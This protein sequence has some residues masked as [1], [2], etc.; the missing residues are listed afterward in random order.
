MSSILLYVAL[1]I[2]GY[3]IY[4]FAFKSK[5]TLPPGPKPLPFLG[6]ILDFPPKD[7]PEFQHWLKH[8]D[9]YGGISSVTV[10]G[11]TLVLIHDKTAVQHL[12]EKT[13]SKTS[14]RPMMTFANKLCGYESIVLCHGY[15]D[16]FKHYRK[17][18]HHELGT[19][20]TAAKFQ[21]AQ[22]VEAKKQL[23]R[24]LDHPQKLLEHF[25]TTASATVLGMA[26]GYTVEPQGADMLVTL[27]D[28]MMTE[29][30]LAAAPMAWMVDIIP[31]LQHIPEWFPGATFQKT[32]KKWRQSILNAAYVPYRF[33]QRQMAAGVQ[34]PSYVSRLVEQCK[35]ESSSGSLDRDDEHAIVWTAAS[36][37]GAAADT[38]VIILT[39]FTLAMTMFPEVQKLAQAE[40]NRVVG[41]DR[42]PGI[43]DR[44]K[45]PYVNALIKETLRWWP[46]A[47]MGFPHTADDDIEYNGVFIPKGA[48]LLPG[49]WWF[50]HDPA[51]YAN[52]EIFDPQRFLP[53]R[54]EPDPTIDAFGYGRRI[55]PG[56]F[57]ADTS[58]YLNV[59]QLLAIFD[60]QKAVDTQ[61]RPVDVNVMPKPGILSYPTSFAFTVVP[62]SKKTVQIIEEVR[63]RYP[64]A[65]SNS[66][67]VQAIVGS[68][69]VFG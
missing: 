17:L 25:Q 61:G 6:N 58:L 12:L 5:R 16:T 56:R 54:S 3:A 53:P 32:A 48:Y 69:E 29:F 40:I 55:C 62:R 30:S 64:E 20:A 49:V 60:I 59:V 9:Q 1:G 10:M 13:A 28:Q 52:P 15:N 11:M 18:L 26:Y 47:P 63:T 24:I 51:V 8:K 33:V 57:F 68:G 4:S 21:E 38:T 23:V 19:K 67:E 36:L 34:Q 39:T 14:G 31:A 27:I 22:G 44:E 65:E 35:T 66:K 45:L 41:F 37:Y 7:V 2:A 43:E 50:L 42:L 46:I